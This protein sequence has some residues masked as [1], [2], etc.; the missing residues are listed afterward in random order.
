MKLLDGIVVLDFSQYLAGPVSALRLAD[1]GA[2][3]IKIERPDAGDGSRQI[4][5]SNLRVDGESTVFQSMNRNKESY[6]ANLKDPSD[7]DKIKKLIQQADVIIE[8]F[9]PG[10][11]KKLGL[12]YESVK[13]LNPRIIYGSVT[14]YGAEGPWKNKPG[15]DLLVQS[16]SGLAWMNG[17]RDQPPVPF[18][19][20]VIDLHTS[21]MF[22][23]TL[24]GMLLQREK[25][26]TGGLVEISLMEAAL[27]FQFE[28]LSAYLNR[29]ERVQPE[30]SEFH[31]AHA[32]L[33]AP[34]GIYE[35]A[36][37]YIALAMGSVLTL[38]ELL[39]CDALLGYTDTST[40]FS[41]RDEIK[42][43]LNAH[44]KTQPTR[45]WLD[46]LEP[47]DYWCAEVMDWESALAHDGIAGLD[48]FQDV[49]RTSGAVFRTTRYP[50]R[51]NGT[52]LKHAKGAPRVG[53]DTDR[54]NEQ[55]ELSSSQQ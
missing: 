30:R 9:R 3:V 50:V 27:D 36:D 24:L 53:E 40:W 20:A 32:Y 43:T 19:L 35:T 49:V 12:D 41:R 31:N 54:I 16:M 39:G 21:S 23:Q 42:R 37:G 25:T 4:T 11:M 34:Y 52:V 29:E 6:A 5:L 18:G 26:G 1:L 10:A 51:V 45:Y 14:G 47:A 2:R 44:L 13:A 15:Q 22:V 17:D 55:F 8:N 28:V 33:G 48:M 38:G 7:L 46:R